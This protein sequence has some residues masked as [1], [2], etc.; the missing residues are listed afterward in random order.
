[1]AFVRRLCDTAQMKPP[2]TA[3]DL[4]SDPE[5][6]P[7]VKHEVV[8]VRFAATDG[9]ITSSVGVNRY[10]AGD[11]LITGSNGDTWSVSRDRFDLRYEQTEA[12]HGYRA[13]RIVVLAKQISETFSIQRTSGGDLLRGAAGDWLMQ[14]A[15]GDF[16]IVDAARF[17]SVYRPA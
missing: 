5:A 10:R 14:Y 11:A 1:M 12:Q 2:L 9:E 16:G 15:P 8:S 17:A 13:R 4:R 6:R 7:Y 3:I